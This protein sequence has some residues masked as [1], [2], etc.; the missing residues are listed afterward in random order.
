[1]QSSTPQSRENIQPRLDVVAESLET[2]QAVKNGWTEVGSTSTDLPMER[3]DQIAKLKEYTH[4]IRG[5]GKFSLKLNDSIGIC[6]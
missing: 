1:M 4:R 2:K 3:K 5:K 6:N